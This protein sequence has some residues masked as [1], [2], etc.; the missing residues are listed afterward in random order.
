MSF[1]RLA[2]SFLTV[3]LLAG[4]GTAGQAP[5]TSASREAAEV[6][7]YTI[8]Q[9][10]GTTLY[11]DAAIS[12][13]GNK[14]A[15][16]SD[17]TGVLNAF[18]VPVAGGEPK[19]LT[20]STVSAVRVIGF[21]PDSERVLY[22][23]DQ[24][25]NE[26]THLYLQ[27]PDGQARDLTPGDKLKA[28]FQDWSLDGRSFFFTTNERDPRYFDVY[29]MPLDSFERKLLFTND[30]GLTYGA[31]S[32]DRRLIALDKPRT[33][34]DVD[35][36][37][38]DRETG[39]LSV[40]LDSPD[41]DVANYSQAFSPDG[42]SLFYTTDEGSE[43]SQ[44][45]RYDLASDQKTEVLSP[46]WDVARVG[47]SRDGRLL[48]AAVNNDAKTEIQLFETTGMRPVQLPKLPDADISEVSLSQDGRHMAFLAESGRSPAVPYVLDLAS[49]EL[50]QLARAL[51]PAIE[52]E[53]LAEAQVVRFKS[54]DGLEIPGL[55]YKP[56]QAGPANKVPAL[57][58][59]HGGP[60]GQSRVSYSGLIQYLVNHGYAVYAINNRGSSGYGKTFYSL[61]DR[62]HG[63][64]DLG[65][66]IA[67]KGMLAGTG[68]VDPDRIG[69]LGGSYG[70]YMVLAAL[71]FRPTEFAV[72]VDLYGVTDWIRT[73]ESIP[74]W[75]E[76]IREG[77]YQE[78]GDPQKDREYLRKISP[79]FHA[80]NI[81][82]PLIVLQGAND[83]RVLRRESDEI[84]AAARKG[85]TP[86]EYLIFPN[87]GHGFRRKETQKQ[88]FEAVLAFLDRYLKNAGATA[89]AAR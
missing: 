70:G 31:M 85:G 68:W 47:L 77:L 39:K 72:G 33:E 12:P 55:L 52:S 76:S 67:S 25:G 30:A 66:C 15:V 42:R 49:G 56:Q 84:V 16:S 62:K 18:V 88:A 40:L 86:V 10:L 79:L 43:F 51:N 8:D 59:V 44:L 14:V 81:E 46:N 41:S 61:D 73:L 13:D 87:E 5:S 11:E 23:S 38:Y 32:P 7:Q 4:C 28:E 20:S 34:K 17:Q 24:G 27:S 48:V 22:S 45:M 80:E 83:P 53:H 9:I 36:Y 37:L 19:Q 54:Y 21:L 35:L 78:L 60:G 3:L 1:R 82:R 74:S 89:P 63:D 58:W 57:V 50:R 75:W 64:A 29:E 71:A 6:P 65:D 2:P 69:I 26:L